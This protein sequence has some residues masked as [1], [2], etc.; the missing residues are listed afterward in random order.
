MTAVFIA[1]TFPLT[2]SAADTRSDAPMVFAG[3]DTET[4]EDAEKQETGKDAGKQAETET[5]EDAGK[6]AATENR[7]ADGSSGPV[8]SGDAADGGNSASGSEKRDESA[9]SASDGAAVRADQGSEGSE[10]YGEKPP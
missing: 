10:T 5:A 2:L 1:G 7:P 4:V 3:S 9:S 8:P 6:Q